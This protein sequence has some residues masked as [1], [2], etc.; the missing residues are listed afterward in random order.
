[1]QSLRTASLL[2]AEGLHVEYAAADGASV[3]ALRGVNFVL[4]PT[5]S[6]GVLGESG[7]GKSTLALALMH[8]L[9]VNATLHGKV[10]FCGRDLLAL[11]PSQLQKIRGAEVALISQEPALALNPVLSIGKQILDV[12]RAHTD[13]SRKDGSRRVFE[14]LEQVGFE[15]PERMMRAYPH[16][17]SGGQRQRAAIAQALVCRPSLLIADE[18]L[19]SLDTVTQAELLDLF[20]QLKSELNLSMIFISHDAA[21]LSTVCERVLVM[22]AGQVAASGTWEQIRATTD[23][24]VRGLQFT[25]ATTCDESSRKNSVPVLNAAPLLEVCNLTKSYVQR[26]VLS[27]EKFEIKALDEV[28]F[29]LKP[30][31]TLAVIGRSGSGKSTLARCIAGFEEPDQ[32]EVLLEGKP[33]RKRSS[34]QMIFQDA[35]TALNPRF[36]AAQLVA[37]PLE[38]ARVGSR[39]ERIERALDLMAEVG[40]DKAWHSRNAGE[41]S[42]GQRQRLALARALSANPK[43][44]IIDESLSGLDL[45]LQEQ[46]LNLL[47]DLQCRHRLAYL[48]ISHDLRFLPMFAQEVLVMDGGRIVERAEPEKLR[49]SSNSATRLLLQA[50]EQVHISRVGAPA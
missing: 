9:P 26:H 24:Y 39:K 47:L 40:L 32:G 41:F 13:I 23:D 25:S 8:L 14:I 17:L 16:Q 28:G 43:I 49:T 35:A 46:I 38:I 19:S 18:P 7:S 10:Q 21:V 44:L 45:S 42:G 30:N 48:F 6:L 15:H 34:I 33:V 1:M 31:A 11:P 3:S 2:R 5:Q 20:R 37:E 4:E 50:N 27:R 29:G 22:K 12:L 36:T